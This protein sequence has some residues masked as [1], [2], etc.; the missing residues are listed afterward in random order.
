MNEDIP[1]EERAR[2]LLKQKMSGT[3]TRDPVRDRTLG[4][5]VTFLID[6]DYVKERETHKGFRYFITKKG[7]EYINNK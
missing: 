1:L 2:I 5:E 7:R 3:I 6:N 4:Q